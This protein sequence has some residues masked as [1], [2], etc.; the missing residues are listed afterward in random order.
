MKSATSLVVT[1]LVV[2]VMFGL[3]SGLIVKNHAK[4]LD[5][6]ND[7]G[8]ITETE[9]TQ[10]KEDFGSIYSIIPLFLV[11]G[12]GIGILYVAFKSRR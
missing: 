3:L 8:Y 7:T 6:L 4:T 12:G 5:V 9:L 10:Q 11:I 1:L 2:M